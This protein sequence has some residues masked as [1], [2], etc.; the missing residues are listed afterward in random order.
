MLILTFVTTCR[1]GFG[2]AEMPRLLLVAVFVIFLALPAVSDKHGASPFVKRAVEKAIR[3]VDAAYKYSR[4]VNLAKLQSVSVKASDRLSFLKR[5]ARDTRTAVRA[6]EYMENALRIIQERAHHIHKRS[7]NATDLLTDDDLNTLVRLTGCAARTRSPSCFTTPLVDKYRTITAVCNNKKNPRLGSSNTPFAR[8]LPPEYENGLFTPR[9]WDPTKLVNG[10]LLPLVREV[11]N[12]IL[13]TH[14]EDVEHDTVYTHLLVIFGQWTDHDLTF[15]P[16]SP[17]IRSFSN[18]INCDASC[19]QAS[20]CFPIR[21]PSNDTRIQDRS[22]CI[23]FFRSAPA[24]GTGDNG[25]AFGAPNVRQQINALTAFLDVGQVYGSE[26]SLAKTLRNL[27]NDLGLLAVNQEFTDNGRELLPFK[28]MSINMCA[29]RRKVTQN[30]SLQEIPCFVAGDVRVDENIGL[31]SVHTLFV[32]EH[33][34]LARALSK[35]NPH[36]SGEEIYQVAR[37]IM[38]GYHQVMTLRDFLPHI[39]GP[40]T[41]ARLL[42]AYTGYDEGIDASIAN[43]F[44]TAAFR[45]AHLMLQPFMFRL[46]ENYKEHPQFPSVLLHNAMFT[47]WRVVFEGGIDPLIRGLAGRPAK[48]NTQEHMMHDELRERLFQLTSR[49]ALDLGS[50]NMQR[51]RDHGLPGYNAWRRFCGL[52]D[53]KNAKQLAGVLNNKDLAD[54]L[55]EL[56]GTPENIDVWLGGVSEPFVKGGRVGP[57]FACLIGTQF[58]KIRNGDRLWWERP[59]VF[60]RRQQESLSR[61]SM[62]R[63]ICDNT[64]IRDVPQDPFLYQPRGSGYTRCSEIPKFDLSPWK[65]AVTAA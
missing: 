2:I 52:S 37:K 29:T 20:P 63:I 58:Q 62:A 45:F 19:D 6:A 47:P 8:W 61:V 18:G 46:D 35:L 41:M 39:V 16:M 60:T 10:R 42:P 57:L 22:A 50:L 1:E 59:E 28:T 26:E 40:D 24:C 48:L 13:S 55:L 17:S 5:P 32:R 51:G 15:T 21:I 30:N 31:T 27:T 25:Y 38:G 33:N 36:W 65:V 49:L 34:R 56:Y 4:E 3:A 9:G 43:V 12:K 64:G 14:N 54:R 44:A 11:S 23:P 53:P 7:L